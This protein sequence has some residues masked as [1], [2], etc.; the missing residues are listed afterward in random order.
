MLSAIGHTPIV[1]LTRLVERTDIEI[2]AKLE[3]LNP[4]GSA[5]DRPAVAMLE[6]GMRRGEIGPRTVIV[7]SSSGNMGV[8]LAQAC[9]RYGLRFRCVVDDR[10]Q[11]TNV[12]LL[13]AYG[14][15]IEFIEPGPEPSFD[16]LAARIAA[17]QRVM[18][19]EADAFWP[20]QY[21]NTANPDSHRTGTMREI[22]EQLRGRF[23]LLV[24]A[25][26]STG[27]AG[28]CSD[29]LDRTGHHAAVVAVDAVGSVLFDGESGERL[30]P[31][32]G[33]G[34][35]PSLAVGRTF[36]RVERVTDAECVLGCRLLAHREAILAGGS[37]GGVVHVVRRISPQLAPGTRV[38][39]VLADRGER[40]LD[41]V[42]DDAWVSDHLN[43]SDGKILRYL[44]E[45]VGPD[46][47]LHT[48]VAS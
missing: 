7:E 47:T 28:G 44:E 27:T 37:S 48:A 40:Y 1:E 14:A 35:V 45:A 19:T 2:H 38:V 12:A 6:Q 22:D 13:R 31:G 17:V 3:L 29:Y 23:D 4:G 34:Q 18:K 26:S 39:V 8:G 16:R 5:K 24:V 15:E 42:Y 43:L 30:I 9:R 33:A 11:P 36:D 21:G 10:I 46:E 32:L 20:N 25:T 41:T